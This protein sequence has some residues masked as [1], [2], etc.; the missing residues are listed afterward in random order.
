MSG[1]G[2]ELLRQVSAYRVDMRMRRAA[3]EKVLAMPDCSDIER[4][5]GTDALM[6]ITTIESFLN[7]DARALQYS[8]EQFYNMNRHTDMAM[9]VGRIHDEYVALRNVEKDRLN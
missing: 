3:I 4:A 9:S 5:I 1:K 8:L 6:H 2:I 7:G